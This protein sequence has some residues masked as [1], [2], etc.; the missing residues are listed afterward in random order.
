M[1]AKI[2]EFAIRE[3][4]KIKGMLNKGTIN[5]SLAIDEIVVMDEKGNLVFSRTFEARKVRDSN[6]FELTKE[7]KKIQM[8]DEQGHPAVIT[9]KGQEAEN[10]DLLLPVV[11]LDDEFKECGVFYVF[12]NYLGGTLEDLQ[13]SPNWIEA[14]NKFY[15]FSESLCYKLYLRK[16]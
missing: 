16:K 7:L 3:L 12:G 9:L 15:D 1:N 5:T 2:Q 10:F 4:L 11:I 13:R 6:L 8:D 14:Q